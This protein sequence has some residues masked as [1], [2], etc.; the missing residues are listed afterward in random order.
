[1]PPETVFADKIR[2]TTYPT[3]E[4]GGVIWAYMGPAALQPPLPEL[5]WTLV[6]ESHVYAHKRFQHCN[7]LQNVEGEV[8]SAHVSF[9]HHEFLAE[10]FEETIAGQVL[11]A[12][13]IDSAPTF[14]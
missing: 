14:L 7:Y 3:R 11:L 12:R 4:T 9:L 1:E 5:E 2:A 10:N 13:A 8:D 6:P